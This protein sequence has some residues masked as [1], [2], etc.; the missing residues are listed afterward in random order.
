MTIGIP[1]PTPIAK[2]PRRLRRRI[3]GVPPAVRQEMF[4][5]D[6][7]TCQWCLRLGGHLDPHHRLARS[8]GGRDDLRTCVSVHRLCHR[9]IHEHPAEAKARGFIVSSDEELDEGWAA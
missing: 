6:R 7:R 5:R 4:A 8:R 9:Y 2:A 3:R 1:K